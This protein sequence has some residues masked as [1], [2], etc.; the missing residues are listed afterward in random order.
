MSERTEHTCLNCQWYGGSC[1]M[2]NFGSI[3]PDDEKAKEMPACQD[4][5]GRRNP[6]AFDDL[7]AACEA[8]MSHVDTCTGEGEGFE[9]AWLNYTEDGKPYWM[10]FATDTLDAIRAAIAKARGEVTP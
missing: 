7:L 2:W 5:E 3:T 6:D 10:S 9:I 8:L 4:W 1:A